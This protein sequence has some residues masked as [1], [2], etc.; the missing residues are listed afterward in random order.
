MNLEHEA[1]LAF[2]GVNGTQGIC[3]IRSFEAPGHRPVVI[4]GELT[5][6]P[7]TFIPNA[8]ET[9]AYTIQTQLYPDGREFQ[10][11]QH[12]PRDEF[13]AVDFQHRPVSDDPDDPAH[14]ASNTV[15][16]TAGQRHTIPGPRMPGDFRDP[17]WT[18]VEAIDTLLRT[19]VQRW[20]PENY[21]AAQIGGEA[22]QQLRDRVQAQNRT[23]S[24]AMLE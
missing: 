15:I 14:L 8:I 9:L 1:L 12:R 11:I 16:I 20:E 2:P 13:Q 21:T 23:A 10:L 17:H 24:D 18:W 22:G 5:D 6:N 4:A 3:H 7:G 19:R